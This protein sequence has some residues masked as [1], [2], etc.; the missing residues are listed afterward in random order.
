MASTRFRSDP[1]LTARM[2]VVMLLLGGLYVSVF[3]A[4]A[5][6]TSLSGGFI[7]FLA[8][9]IGIGQWYFSDRIAMA[10]MRA[11]EVS[12]EEAPE[13]HAMVDRLCA[14]ADMPK[15]RV[16]ITDTDIPNAFATGRSPRNAVVC[17]T[18]GIMRR[19]D[20]EEL[21]GVLSHELSHVAHRDVAVMT[22]AGFLGI[23]AGIFM[24]WGMFMGGGRSRDSQVPFLVIWLGSILVYFISFLLTRV[25]SRYRELSADRSGAYLTGKPSALASALTKITGDMARIPD[26]DLR[27][28]QAFNSFFF[29][30]AFSR[31]SISGLFS[32]HPPI[33]QRLEQLAKISADLSR[34]TS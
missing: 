27:S 12:P 34:P 1:G 26:R 16:A 29:A 8:A 3:A 9:A 24:R 10:A 15:P 5:A 7:L 25:L 6:F 13:L 31:E 19:L 17:V 33:E 21:E 28:V 30:P 20:R 4:L 11:R 18:T 14:L 2:S 22:I 32:T 23:A